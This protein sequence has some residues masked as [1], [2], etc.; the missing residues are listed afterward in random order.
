MEAHAGHRHDGLARRGSARLHQLVRHVVAS[1]DPFPSPEVYDHI[2]YGI[3]TARV[4][5]VL[6]AAA[7]CGLDVQHV[8]H[9]EK[10]DW[11]LALNPKG[12]VPTYKSK[13]IVLNESNTIVSYF[14]SKFGREKGLYPASEK[15]VALAW[16][17]AEWGESSVASITTAFFYAIVRK[18]Y[19]VTWALQGPD[20][21]F[22]CKRHFMLNKDHS[23]SR[24]EVA[25][26]ASAIGKI[27]TDLEAHLADGD[28]QYILGEEF[29]FADIP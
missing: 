1:E 7:E 3:P 17:W 8:M 14:A 28:K 21:E 12:T 16:Q 22:P 26:L 13:D 5:K 18:Q 27:L 10:V 23:P 20:R 4:V 2:I 24:E 29:P 9:A 19:H 25:P 15:D 11:Y 6:W